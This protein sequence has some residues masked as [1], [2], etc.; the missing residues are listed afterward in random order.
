MI[1]MRGDMTHEQ[2]CWGIGL[3]MQAKNEFGEVTRM[4]ADHV[5]EIL[6]K[7]GLESNLA[8]IGPL[9]ID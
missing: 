2:L 8:A 3:S 5:A 9:S 7:H 4:T 6:R 1:M